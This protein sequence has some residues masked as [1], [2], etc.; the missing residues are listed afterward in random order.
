MYKYY[1]TIGEVKNRYQQVV[2]CLDY[3][4]C[5]LGMV[6]AIRQTALLL[7]I[8]T[9]AYSVVLTSD[10]GQGA[11][12][13]FNMLGCLL[14]FFSKQFAAKLEIALVNVYCHV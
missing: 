5:F 8:C 14:P 11:G 2:N 9:I 6:V 13:V 12:P 7:D 1:S 10:F 4:P 3:R